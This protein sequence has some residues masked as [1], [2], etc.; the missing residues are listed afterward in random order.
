MVV[1]EMGLT[2]VQYDFTGGEGGWPGDVPRFR[3]DVSYINKLGWKAKRNSAE[4]V[5]IAIR[6]TLARMSMP[7]QSPPTQVLILAGGLGTRLHPITETIPKPM[8]P[9]A[10]RPYLEYQLREL[11]RQNC[12]DVVLLTGYLGEQI[13]SHF[14]DGASL[15][16]K[17]RY[18]KEDRPMGT[19]GAVRDAGDLLA[20]SFLIVYGDSYLPISYK[21][22]IL[23]LQESTA[24]GI[25]VIYDNR[26]EDTSVQNNV[27]IDADGFVTR[28]DKVNSVGLDYVEAGVLA[29][30]RS[31]LSLLP[32]EGVVSME[33]QLFPQLIRERRLL[34]Y[35][36]T[37]RFYDIGTPERLKVIEEFI[38]R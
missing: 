37:Q 14:K 36:T 16:L 18:S 32:S 4:A 3:L 27:A 8:V 2:N 26:G 7:D 12:T 28:Y 19:G 21:D 13:E 24:D 22:V 10:G 1:E 38:T 35:P 11:A 5:R 34:A 23:K 29:L 17:L 30:R 15:G 31:T 25:I 20:E 6:S 33:Q 9:V